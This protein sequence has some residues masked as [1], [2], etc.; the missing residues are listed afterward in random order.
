MTNQ[1]LKALRHPKPEFDERAAKDQR[2]HLRARHLRHVIDER[3]SWPAPIVPKVRVA[4]TEVTVYRPGHAMLGGV[5]RHQVRVSVPSVS[6]TKCLVCGK[7]G[8]PGGTL[9]YVP[10]ATK[11]RYVHR[12]HAVGWS[13]LSWD[14]PWI[15]QRASARVGVPTAL[16]GRRK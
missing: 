3:W 10:T 2:A 9:V 4:P 13:R 11:D 5:V 8:R 15:A 7:C 14:R 1:Q 6:M 12:G 16:W